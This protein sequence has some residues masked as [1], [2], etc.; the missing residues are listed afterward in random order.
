MGRAMGTS[1][2]GSLFGPAVGALA[3]VTGRAAL[4]CAL[5]VLASL[6][7]FPIASL[8]D[9]RGSTEQPVSEVI[10][11]LS[12]P[13]LMIAMWL[14]ALPAVVSGAFNVL[15]PLQ[16]H[17]L[18]AGAAVIGVTFLVG[19]G[20]ESVVSPLAGGFSDRH[21]RALPLLIGLLGVAAGFA[22]FTLPSVV[23]LLVLLMIATSTML[24][25][26]WA[27][28]MALVSDIAEAYG[29]DQAH[30]AALMN[31]AWALGLRSPARPVAAPPARRGVTASRLWV[32]RPC[33]C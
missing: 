32:P 18:G 29:I 9:E 10:R 28:V 15:G 33:A 7:L 17:H 30:A 22:C 25:V 3:S 12:R 26:F 6:L 14:M 2:A 4:F 8:H 13:R 19:A 24:G 16:L 20:M 27:P 1:L 21:G 11:L 23:V 5:A 31:L